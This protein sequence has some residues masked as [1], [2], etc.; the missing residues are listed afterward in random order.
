MQKCRNFN[1]WRFYN[2]AIML[3]GS[4]KEHL[5]ARRK[6]TASFPGLCLGAKTWAN[7]RWSSTA[8]TRAL[9][10]IGTLPANKLSQSIFKVCF[11]RRIERRAAICCNSW[12]RRYSRSYSRGVCR[13]RGWCCSITETAASCQYSFVRE[14]RRREVLHT[15]QSCHFAFEHLHPNKFQKVQH[16]MHSRT[17]HHWHIAHQ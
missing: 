9:C 3:L 17:E 16:S 13:A 15:I 12:C 2:R 11:S 4:E 6:A 1:K 7:S 10:V 14:L 5:C 8:T